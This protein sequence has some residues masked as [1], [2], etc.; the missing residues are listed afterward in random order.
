MPC[1]CIGLYILSVGSVTSITDR[2]I[3][4]QLNYL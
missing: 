3:R 4:D 1:N 2:R